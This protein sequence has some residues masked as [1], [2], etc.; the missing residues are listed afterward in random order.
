MVAEFFGHELHVGGYVGE[1]F[2]EAGA[3]VVEAVFAVGGGGDAIFW[4][5]SVAEVEVGA[6]L[7]LV[8]QAGVFVGAEAL[9]VG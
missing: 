3:E 6:G 7:A 8:G 4:T 5:F 1:V 2:F 9:L